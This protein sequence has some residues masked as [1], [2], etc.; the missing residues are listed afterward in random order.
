[1]KP[2]TAWLTTSL[3][4]SALFLALAIASASANDRDWS[5]FLTESEAGRIW[6]GDFRSQSQCEPWCIPDE[7]CDDGDS[8]CPNGNN[9]VCARYED[10]SHP[11]EQTWVC[12]P[13]G[14][15]LCCTTEPF[16]EAHFLKCKCEGVGDCVPTLDDG[17]CSGNTECEHVSS[18]M[19][20]Q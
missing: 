17:K 20:C 3:A 13:E 6:G 18:Q 14:A 7:S 4:S 12:A 5:Q 9:M 16:G 10:P 1:M 19:Q 11:D 8:D 15:F 2:M